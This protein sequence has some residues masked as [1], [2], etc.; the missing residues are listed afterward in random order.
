MTFFKKTS[1]VTFA[2]LI[3]LSLSG[4]DDKNTP[5]KIDCDKAVS[6]MNKSEKQACGKDGQ[7]TKS[8]EKGW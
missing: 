8:P 5:K 4:C 7:Y 2:V 6:D 1:V 3:A